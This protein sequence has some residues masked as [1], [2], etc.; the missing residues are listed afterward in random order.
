M[1][2]KKKR[3]TKENIA[4]VANPTRHGDTR[5][6][7]GKSLHRVLAKKK[8]TRK[9][10]REIANGKLHTCVSRTTTPQ[11]TKKSIKSS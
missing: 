11:L 7:G 8:K 10:N 5:L 6:A 2:E 4:G 9:K 1:I 3:E